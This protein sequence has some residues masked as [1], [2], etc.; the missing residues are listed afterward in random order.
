MQWTNNHHHV[1][2]EKDILEGGSASVIT[3]INY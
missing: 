3:S 2:V 1:L